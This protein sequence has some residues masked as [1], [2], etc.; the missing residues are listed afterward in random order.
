MESTIYCCCCCC[1]WYRQIAAISRWECNFVV[2][3]FGCVCKRHTGESS[4]TQQA[5]PKE[6]D[7]E[8]NVFA[9]PNSLN[10]D[11]HTH[12]MVFLA[13][14]CGVEPKEHHTRIKKKEVQLRV[15]LTLILTHSTWIYSNTLWLFV[16]C[17]C[18][19]SCVLIIELLFFALLL[20]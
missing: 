14:C 2:R 9:V 16:C 18:F 7:G 20:K 12:S 4:Y 6:L 5:N 15:L 13:L 11:I 1:W 10:V 19:F 3:A 17:V 8:N